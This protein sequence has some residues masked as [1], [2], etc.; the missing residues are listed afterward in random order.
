VNERVEVKICGLTRYDDAMAA[1]GAGATYGGVILA[2]GSPRTVAPDRVEEIF[3][4]TP[5]VRCGVFVNE[6]MMHISRLTERLRL[7]VIQLHGD[8]SAEFARSLRASF[9]VEVWKAI[10]PRS[11]EDFAAAAKAFEDSVDGVLVDGWSASARGG[12]GARFPWR[13]VAAR[14]AEVAG[15]LKLIAAG[16]LNPENVAEVIALL[17]P[18]VVDVSSGVERSPGIKD[19][20]AIRRFAAAAR[21]PVAEKGV[22]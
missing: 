6:S 13:E 4:D 8:E 16:G 14:R 22:A 9:D 21:A 5:L 7:G 3:G 17:H 19:A 15:S 20:G 11:A 10:R 1:A 12:T 18:E 2:N